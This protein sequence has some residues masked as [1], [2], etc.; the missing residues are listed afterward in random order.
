MASDYDHA[1]AAVKC[2]ASGLGL[3][4]VECR[5]NSIKIG[6]IIIYWDEDFWSVCAPLKYLPEDML[7][8]PKG[9]LPP[10]LYEQGTASIMCSGWSAAVSKAFELLLCDIVNV[11]L[12]AERL[13]QEIEGPEPNENLN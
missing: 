5:S 8:L 4:D 12:D 3:K 2:I 1:T 6:P 11:I 13:A 10:T 7:P 9:M